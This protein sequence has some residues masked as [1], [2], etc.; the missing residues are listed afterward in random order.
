[1]SQAPITADKDFFGKLI[2]FENFLNFTKDRGKRS[3]DML[4]AKN[5]HNQH[6]GNHPVRVPIRPLSI[7]NVDFN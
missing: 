3:G 7:W 1:M 2:I 5:D 4:I 6:C